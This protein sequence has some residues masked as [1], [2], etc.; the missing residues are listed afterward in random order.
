MIGVEMT[1]EKTSDI[2]G[3]YV[4]VGNVIEYQEVVVKKAPL[5][6]TSLILKPNRCHVH[7]QS[8]H[9]PF[10][11]ED[12]LVSHIYCVQMIKN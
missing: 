1:G 4:K 6:F 3:S 12:G 11:G 5:L 7:F 9:L 2:L 10:K 8:I